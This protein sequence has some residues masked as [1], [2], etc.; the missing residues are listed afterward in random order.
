MHQ[1]KL[2]SY[3]PK[4]KL[5]YLFLWVCLNSPIKCNN[6]NLLYFTSQYNIFLVYGC[7]KFIYHIILLSSS[8]SE[9]LHRSQNFT[10]VNNTVMNIDL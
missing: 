6:L 9:N 5:Q 10:I 7:I 4:E 8:A 2:Y 1:Y 3:Q